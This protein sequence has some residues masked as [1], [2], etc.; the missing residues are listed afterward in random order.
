MFS[1]KE[2]RNAQTYMRKSQKMKHY[3]QENKVLG[4][5][6]QKDNNPCVK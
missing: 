5:N 4:T 2:R 1:K 6:K 3:S